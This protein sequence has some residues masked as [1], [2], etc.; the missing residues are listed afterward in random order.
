MYSHWIFWWFRMST[1]HY[2]TPDLFSKGCL[3][4]KKD[5]RKR[6]YREEGH[7]SQAPLRARLNTTHHRGWVAHHMKLVFLAN[8]GQVLSKGASVLPVWGY[9]GTS[10]SKEWCTENLIVLITIFLFLLIYISEIAISN[11]YLVLKRKLCTGSSQ[12]RRF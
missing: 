6:G 11:R 3:A 10:I 8:R 5:W 9:Q 1:R 12:S 4:K 7:V 2:C